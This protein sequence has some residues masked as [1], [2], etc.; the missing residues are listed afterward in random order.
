MIEITNESYINVTP[1]EEA[2]TVFIQLP[3]I[4]SRRPRTQ[5]SECH[6]LFM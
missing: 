1:N 4:Y 6:L 2:V 5:G 3:S